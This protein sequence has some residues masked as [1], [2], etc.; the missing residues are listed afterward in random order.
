MDLEHISH[1]LY[2]V[3]ATHPYTR[4]DVYDESD[5]LDDGCLLGVM[6]ST[7]VQGISPENFTK[8]LSDDNRV[9]IC[10][11]Y[12]TKGIWFNR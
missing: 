9:C 2:K 4:D 5:G 10:M 7:G 8:M 6:E 12:Q 3:L 11:V 1:L